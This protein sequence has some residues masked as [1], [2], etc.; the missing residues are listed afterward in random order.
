MSQYFQADGRI[1]WNPSTAVSQVF[2]HAAA[3]EIRRLF[4]GLVITQSQ[5]GLA[6]PVRVISDIQ[7]WSH[8]RRLHQGQ[9]RRSHYR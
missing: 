3:A 8:W 7:R 5:A 4:N 9:A 2:L 1:V 6:T